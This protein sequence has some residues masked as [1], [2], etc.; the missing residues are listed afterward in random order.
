MGRERF[1]YKDTHTH[2]RAHLC[3]YVLVAATSAEEV[4]EE[5]L[6]LYQRHCTMCFCDDMKTGR[7]TGG[8]MPS[9]RL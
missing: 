6:E 1:A 9:S 4:R 2:A 8:L 7:Q 5:E 3:I